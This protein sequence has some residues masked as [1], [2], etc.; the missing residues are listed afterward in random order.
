[1]TWGDQSSDCALPAGEHLMP[2]FQEGMPGIQSRSFPDSAN[3]V[4]IGH[5]GRPGDKAWDV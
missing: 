4:P 5:D 3:S 2:V 1:M